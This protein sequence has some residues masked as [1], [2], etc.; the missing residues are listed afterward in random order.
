[1]KR[2][3]DHPLW[4]LQLLQLPQSILNGFLGNIDR[5]HLLELGE[6]SSAPRVAIRQILG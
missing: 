4:D 3:E 1:M 5:R 6:N 2:I